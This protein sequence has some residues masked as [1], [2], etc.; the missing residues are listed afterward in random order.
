MVFFL[1]TDI[2]LHLN[3]FDSLLKYFDKPSTFGVTGR[4]INPDKKSTPA[5]GNPFFKEELKSEEKSTKLISPSNST[6]FISGSNALLSRDK[7][8]QLNGFDEI[9]SPFYFE[10]TDL[11]TR[12]KRLGW[13]CYEDHD[14]LC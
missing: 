4:I 6:S 5:N 14:A 1:N 11:C 9:Y 7:L 3:Y 10:D 2:K 8:E 12:A 13:D